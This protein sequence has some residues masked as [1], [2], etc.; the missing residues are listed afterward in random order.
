MNAQLLRQ[1]ALVS[2]GTQFLRGKLP[3]DAWYRHGI[4]F[5][6]RLQFREA[7]D[8]RLLA[9]DF[10]LWLTVLQGTGARRL[11]LHPRA[12][13]AVAALHAKHGG[14]YVIAVHFPE[15][16]QLWIVGL[17]QPA[18]KAQGDAFAEAMGGGTFPYVPAAASYAGQL[19]SYWCMEDIAGA[20]PVPATDW[21][22]LAATIRDDLDVDVRPA[23]MPAGP[24]M[25]HS[26]TDAQWARLPV[27]V[28]ARTLVLPHQ[29]MAVLDVAKG[30]YDNDTHCKNE[31]NLYNFMGPEASDRLFAWSQ[32]LDQWIIDVALRCANEDRSV[33]STTVPAPTR[34]HAGTKSV[35]AK[36]AAGLPAHAGT[37]KDGTSKDGTIEDRISKDRLR[38]DGTSKDR[39]SKDG[40]SKDGSEPA[41]PPDDVTLG[42][43]GSRLAFALMLAI[44]GIA[45][46]AFCLGI[47]RYPKLGIVAALLVAYYLGK[48]K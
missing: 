16:Y 7:A 24:F 25:A 32:R 33:A 34:A 5:E 42:K 30:K 28:Y 22:K 1:V 12:D 13:F 19:D 17:E 44:I 35:P 39:T 43:W 9:D 4:F 10:T 11:S 8:R 14:D 20:L 2:Y 26:A 15:R 6:S 27:F 41:S 45:L 21:G 38:K 18:W 3:F 23:A 40:T 31:G 47:A 37:G 36:S 48:R 46:L 29:L